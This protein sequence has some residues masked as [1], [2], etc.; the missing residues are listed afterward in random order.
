MGAAGDVE[1]QAVG[2]VESDERGIAFGPVGDGGE[3][4]RVG[5]R[6]D[7]DCVE[8]RD[9]GAGVGQRLAAMEPEPLG[10]LVESDEAERALHL[11]DDDEGRTISFPCPDRFVP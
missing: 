6:V 2:R 9:H 8:F 1:H 3:K 11:G 4:R 7:V 10:G 5:G